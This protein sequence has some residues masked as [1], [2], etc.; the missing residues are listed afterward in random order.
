MLYRMLIAAGLLCIGVQ[1]ATAFPG[2]CLLEITGR[3][4]LNGT[5]NIVLQEGGS[6]TIGRGDRQHRSRHSAAVV[7]DPQEGVAYG[8][9]NGRDAKGPMDQE[10]G[11]LTRQGGCWINDHA[12]VCAWRAATRARLTPAR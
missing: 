6:F 12:K 11:A 8:H 3:S 9:W 5:C 10:L 1:A 7:L 2:E 4:Y